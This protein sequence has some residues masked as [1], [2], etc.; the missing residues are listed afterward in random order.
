M[1]RVGPLEDLL[2]IQ[3]FTSVSGRRRDFG[4]LPQYVGFVVLIR[5]VKRTGAEKRQ[6]RMGQGLNPDLPA[7]HGERMHFSRRLADRPYHPEVANGRARG[8]EAPLE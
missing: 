1:Y 7:A 6:P 2:R 3:P 4:K 8:L 5:N